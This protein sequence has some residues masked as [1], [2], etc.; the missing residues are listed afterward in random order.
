MRALVYLFSLQ[1]FTQLVIVCFWILFYQLLYLEHKLLISRYANIYI[2]NKLEEEII[3]LE[4][5]KKII[6][7]NPCVY[8]GHRPLAITSGISLVSLSVQVWKLPQGLRRWGVIPPYAWIAGK[9]HF[10][11]D[12]EQRLPAFFTCGCSMPFPNFHIAVHGVEGRRLTEADAIGNR[13]QAILLTLAEPSQ[14]RHLLALNSNRVPV[15]RSWRLWFKCNL[16]QSPW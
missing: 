2:L 7:L 9:F 8:K 4:A 12:V 10:S 6:F 1:W 3:L 16:V 11:G 15:R 14:H 5:F 13:L